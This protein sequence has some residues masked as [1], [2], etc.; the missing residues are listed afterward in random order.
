MRALLSTATD[1]GDLAN[2]S[3][4][5]T[6]YRF[7]SIFHAE[8]FGARRLKRQRFKLMKEID[9]HLQNLLAEGEEVEFISWGTEFSLAEHYFMGL[10]AQLINRCALLCTNQRLL[11]LQINS[12]RKVMDLKSQVRYQ[13]IEKFAPGMLGALALVLRDG[14]KLMLTGIPRKDRKPMKALI[15]GK[16]EAARADARGSG[17]ENLCPHCGHRV[18]GYPDR[19]NRCA[20]PFKSGARAGWLS[21]VFPGLGDFYLGHRALGVVEMLGAAVAWG[22]VVVPSALA[23]TAEPGAYTEVAVLGGIVFAFVH[24][25]D[26]WITRRVGFKGIYP[27]E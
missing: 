8:G 10:W 4:G 15:A 20:G 9:S 2:V 12:K 19:C 27:A 18:V 16:L 3:G 24:G 22:I 21:L 5:S 11:I 14:K 13:A 17:R 1:P 23:A 25:V 26:C 6:P 7:D